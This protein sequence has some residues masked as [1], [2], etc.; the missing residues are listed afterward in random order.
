[1]DT[2]FRSTVFKIWNKY[3][4]NVTETNNQEV[5]CFICFTRTKKYCRIAFE[6]V[7]KF[8]ERRHKFYCK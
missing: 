5:L 8:W 3:K 2:G 7:P 4:Q 1:M 6:V